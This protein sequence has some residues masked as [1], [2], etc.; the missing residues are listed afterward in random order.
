MHP[1]IWKLIPL[2]KK[3]GILV[4]KKKCDA[5]GGDNSAGQAK[6]TN[7]N[8]KKKTV[9]YSIEAASVKNQGIWEGDLF[10]SVRACAGGAGFF[11]RLLQ[12]QKVCE[13]PFPSSA[14]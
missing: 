8:N 6:Q 2:L 9:I 11:G 13:T 10:P 5:K 14:P 1:S 4:G 3:E 7:N 12:E